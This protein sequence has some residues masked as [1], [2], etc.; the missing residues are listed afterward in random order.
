MEPSITTSALH[1][2][3]RLGLE[4]ASR[5]GFRSVTLSAAQPGLR[6]R[7]LDRS[8]RRGL[9]AELRRLE[10]ECS[11]IDLFIPP[12]HFTSTETIERALDAV[13][14]ALDL[15]T[16]LGARSLFLRL[17]SE[18]LEDAMLESTEELNRL[19]ESRVVR[20]LD[21][22]LSGRALRSLESAQPIAIGIGLDTASWLAD[23]R[24]P[25]EGLI[26]HGAM[27]G[28]LRLV[29]LDETGSR[30]APVAGGRIDLDSLRRALTLEVQPRS[31]VLDAR[32]W[33]DPLS[34]SARSLAL[35]RAETGI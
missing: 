9:L 26:T 17:P 32:G 33:A 19:A 1:S 18:S 11:S 20:L 10:L 30:T 21:V 3:P 34:D 27:V 2:E 8:A 7:E 22:G 25:L 4:L 23:Q 5:L 29:D 12:E 35:W 16:D 28:G 31:V 6:P 15:A 24:D 14:G 13:R